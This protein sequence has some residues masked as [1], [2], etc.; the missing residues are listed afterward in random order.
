MILVYV[1]VLSSTWDELGERA[2]ETAHFDSTTMEMP[3]IEEKGLTFAEGS[4]EEQVFI[5]EEGNVIH[6]MQEFLEAYDGGEAEIDEAP[7]EEFESLA[8][9]LSELIS[10]SAE[11]CGSALFS[12]LT[13]YTLSFVSVLELVRRALVFDSGFAFTPFAHQHALFDNFIRSCAFCRRISH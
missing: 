8:Q 5:D 11:A 10:L 1:C 13:S 12:L 9:D 7:T 3:E 6:Q 4:L 2:D